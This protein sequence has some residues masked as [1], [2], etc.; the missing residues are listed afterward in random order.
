ML[1]SVTQKPVTQNLLPMDG[2]LPPLAGLQAPAD[3]GSGAVPGSKGRERQPEADVRGLP[4]MLIWSL[5]GMAVLMCLA[6]FGLALFSWRD[7][8]P[9]PVRVVGLLSAPALLWLGYAIAARHGRGSAEVAVSFAGLSWADVLLVCR[10]CMPG[11]PLWSLGVA[12]L[13]FHAVLFLIRPWKSAFLL[14]ALSC[15]LESVAL[16][17]EVRD[18]ETFFP[19]ALLWVS[20]LTMLMLCAL[21]GSWCG[22]TKR[23]GYA[24]YK[25]AGPVSF[26]LCLL[27]YLAVVAL[28]QF[29]QPAELHGRMTW[30]E[31]GV[32][33]GM[34]LAPLLLMLP[35]HMARARL[36]QRPVWSYSFFLLY[37]VTFAAVPAGVDLAQHAPGAWG[38]PLVFAYAA[39]IIYYGAD[40][41]SPWMALA[42]CGT[43]FLTSLSI[44]LS[45]RIN[46]L[47]GAFVMLGLGF[48]F[49]YASFRLY[50]RRRQLQTR[51][52]HERLRR[53]MRQNIFSAPPQEFK[54]HPIAFSIA[55]KAF[56][57]PLSANVGKE[58]AAPVTQ[59]N[60]IRCGT[61][62]L[63]VPLAPAAPAQGQGKKAETRP[64]IHGK[65]A[66]G[67]DRAPSVPLR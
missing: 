50:A 1:S 26:A 2:E 38:I 61:R 30:D 47:G 15:V 27:A 63:S 52:C 45:E 21:C 54:S 19:W 23:P 37:A 57:V 5:G 67:I 48:L 22:K 65:E 35:L 13:A 43:I 66:S 12:F 36:A 32:L 31:W 3:S 62:P 29:F 33:A 55:P 53:Q 4:L 56:T 18:N 11:L 25:W 24:C 64:L 6:G 16:W 14:L 7:V 17:H 8:L 41:K 34:W 46:P 51:I 59:G 42:G 28:P 49:L 10:E 60:A 9:L 58:S 39:C 40:Y 44:M 20:V